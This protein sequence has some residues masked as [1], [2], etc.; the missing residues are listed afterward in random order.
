MSE[1]WHSG[2]SS[3]YA[4]THDE[5]TARMQTGPSMDQ[6]QPP[7]IFQFSI[8]L[9]TAFL[10]QPCT[11]LGTEG[12]NPSDGKQIREF[13]STHFILHTD[14]DATAAKARLSKMESTLRI[15][16]DYWGRRLKGQIHCYLVDDLKAWPAGSLPE[17]QARKVLLLVGGETVVD[18]KSIQSRKVP[19]ASIYATTQPGVVEHE[20]IHAY[21]FQVFGTGGPQWY[22]EGM[23]ELFAM[24]S[25]PKTGAVCR[26]A[27]LSVLKEGPPLSLKQVL[28]LENFTDSISQMIGRDA[29]PNNRDSGFDVTG[30][31][32]NTSNSKQLKSAQVAYAQCWALCYLL[33]HNPN[34]EKRFRMLGRNF[35]N[36]NTVKF[37]D[38]FRPVMRN[39]DFELKQ[40][41]KN[42][43]DGYRADLCRWNWSKTFDSIDVGESVTIP[44]K[45]NAG[46]QATQLLVDCDQ[47]YRITSVGDWLVTKNAA[48]VDANGDH[49]GHGQLE[50]AIFDNFKLQ[51]PLILGS[52]ALLQTSHEGFVYL[53]C[54]DN[55]LGL[56]DNRG[57]IHVR[58]KRIK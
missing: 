22:R 16:I 31:T 4:S 17:H 13:R 8:T 25:K 43:G 11:C 23:A 37:E 41:G 1:F 45:A 52:Q 27:T 40:F 28:A 2:T 46:Y 36:N 48:R 32:W 44:L 56:A 21:C 12:A 15:G 5:R 38:L 18:I 14:L 49:S 6:R 33:H 3:T 55:W 42:I 57:T 19:Q 47:T 20:V 39:I 51:P 58:L 9:L 35:L 29:D 10:L 30:E 50:V 54:H 34:Y 26:E 7:F 24:N 53:R